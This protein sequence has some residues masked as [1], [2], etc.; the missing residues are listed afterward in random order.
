MMTMLLKTIHSPT[1]AAPLSTATVLLAFCA[2][3]S[4]RHAS[5]YYWRI[6]HRLAVIASA[7][8]KLSRHRDLL[9]E[10]DRFLLPRRLSQ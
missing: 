6:L 7:P 9:L 4:M 1:L 8:A 10:P 5:Y 3:G 2:I